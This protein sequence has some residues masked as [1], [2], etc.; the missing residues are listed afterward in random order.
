MGSGMTSTRPAQ[1]SAVAHDPV[2]D[3]EVAAGAVEG[4][5]QIRRARDG[6][7]DWGILDP[8]GKGQR[9]SSRLALDGF[10]RQFLDSS[11]GLMGPD[12]VGRPSPNRTLGQDT[13]AG[14]QVVHRMPARFPGLSGN[15]L[16][17]TRPLPSAASRHQTPSS[18]GWAWRSSR[19]LNTA[20]STRPTVATASSIACRR[21]KRL[22]SM[23]GIPC[24]I[25]FSTS[26][27]KGEK[28]VGRRKPLGQLIKERNKIETFFP[29]GCKP[30]SKENQTIK[31][32]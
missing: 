3:L 17:A 26:V 21:L 1:R 7:V 16:S 24:F 5:L 31:I 25:L 11:G 4:A 13:H 23:R 20:S 29:W 22:L 32:Q 2:V 12:P 18:G 27:A 28:I 10:V 30:V 19:K 8:G 6:S 15:T 14:Q 9:L